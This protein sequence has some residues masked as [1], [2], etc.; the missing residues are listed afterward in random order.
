MTAYSTVE[1]TENSSNQTFLYWLEGPDFEYKWTNAPLDV[2]ATI[3]TVDHTF[4]HPRGGISHGGSIE[5]PDSGRTG[6]DIRVSHKN[7]IIR[8]HRAFP[9]PGDTDVTI[10]R[11]NEINGETYR[12][13]AGILVETPIE[14][15]HAFLRCQHV[16]EL[17][18]G[19]EGLTETFGAT[20]PYML[21]FN[22]CPVSL[23]AITDHG[24]LVTSVDPDNLKVTVSGSVRIAGK[25]TVGVLVA[26]NGDKR[27]ILA[28]AI[29][30]GDHVF[31]L[32]QNFP[33]TT[34]KVGDEVDVI[35]GCNK[36]QLTCRD[37][38]GFW[39]G[40]GAAFGGNNLQS[41]KN[42]HEIGRLE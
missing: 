35:L 41:N 5:S 39:T 38:F 34:L 4:V 30:A 17:I 16:Y 28:D 31:T 27:M 12:I 23:P 24:L 10:F 15:R 40:N 18:S 20:C 32:Q 1:V 42:P 9:P 26:P 33:S 6:R 8:R 29:P 14:G 7:P 13:W 21:G 25:Y 37:E 19:S 11:Q 36:L 2:A 3:D 22:P